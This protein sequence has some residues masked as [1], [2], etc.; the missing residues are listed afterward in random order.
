MI[1]LCRAVILGRGI[2]L[3]TLKGRTSHTDFKA[4]GVST[5][6]C[7]MVKKKIM[8]CFLWSW[9]SH[10]VIYLN[11]LKFLKR[12]Q[13]SFCVGVWGSNCCI[14]KQATNQTIRDWLLPSIIQLVFYPLDGLMLF[15]KLLVVQEQSCRPHV[16]VFRW[17]LMFGD[18]CVSPCRMTLYFEALL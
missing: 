17:G 8:G 18:M 3:R 14:N 2:Y 12:A 16:S 11:Y 13:V 10:G 5:I 15:H 6:M 4:F 9:K 7:S 1:D